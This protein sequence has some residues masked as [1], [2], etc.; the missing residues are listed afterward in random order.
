MDE[1]IEVFSMGKQREPRFIV[2]KAIE[3]ERNLG[4]RDKKKKKVV[5]VKH[6]D[7]PFFSKIRLFS[8]WA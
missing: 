6:K 3:E 2:K 4:E 8:M 5:P 1:R 7:H